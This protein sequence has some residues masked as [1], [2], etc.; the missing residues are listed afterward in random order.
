MSIFDGTI[1][2]MGLSAP[3]NLALGVGLLFFNVNPL[4]IEKSARNT[5]DGKSCKTH[6]MEL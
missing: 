1:K 3:L 5:A 2:H 4:G 6:V